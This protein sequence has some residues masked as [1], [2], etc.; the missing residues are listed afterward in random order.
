MITNSNP[1]Y[2]SVPTERGY[3]SPL[4]TKVNEAAQPAMTRAL[5]GGGSIL[6]ANGDVSTAKLLEVLERVLKNK[7]DKFSQ[8]VQKADN[9][10]NTQGAAN[11]G[12]GAMLE[13]QQALNDVNTT[14]QTMTS[15]ISGIGEAL[16]DVARNS[17]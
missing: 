4:A 1:D 12:N 11:Q 13:A 15:M 8:A 2:Y 9:T 17:K 10:S 6:D 16:K 7:N 5:G 14:T 3:G